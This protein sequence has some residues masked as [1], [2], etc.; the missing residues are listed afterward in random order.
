MNKEKTKI[1]F[2]GQG[3]IGKNYADDFEDRGYN[4]VRY[5]RE[6]QYADNKD[7]IKDCDIVFIA[8]PT[9]TTPDGFDYSILDEVLDLVG[10]N[11][12]AVIKSTML[13]GTTEKLQEKHPYVRILHSPEFLTEAN[14]KHDA[15]HP[16]R[17]IIGTTEKDDEALEL[18][19]SILDILPRAPYELI[20]S[21]RE[22]ELIKYAG[23]NLLYFKV[24]LV[25]MLYDIALKNDCHWEVI[26][27]ALWHD[28][29]LGTSH[30]DP[31]HDGGRGAGGH[32]FIKDFAA[33]EQL[34]REQVGDKEGI[35]VF[36][37]LAAKNNALLRDTDKNID[38]LEGVYG[39]T[40]K[41]D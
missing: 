26:K 10:L 24:L 27:E 34:Y 37:A 28:D 17:N 30:F 11:K 38:L 21:A 36:E 1:G 23:N 7:K 6:E 3:F 9:P 15:S 22:A 31:V 39:R 5:A 35:A 32:C 14:A 2:I 18:C 19:Q 13:P 16:K 25:N 20:C 41:K 12:I 4:V 29:R 8:V 33:L 40:T